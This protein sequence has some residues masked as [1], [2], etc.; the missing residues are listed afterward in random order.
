VK[1]SVETIYDEFSRWREVDFGVEKDVAAK[2]R[3]A[4]ATASQPLGVISP[5]FQK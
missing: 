5:P 1:E 4:A 2:L 3:R